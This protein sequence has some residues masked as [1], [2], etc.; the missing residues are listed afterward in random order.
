MRDS[1]L[2]V[3]S[4]LH[5]NRNPLVGRRLVASSNGLRLVL[6]FPYVFPVC[7]CQA[8]LNAS[9]CTIHGYRKQKDKFCSQSNY[10]FMMLEG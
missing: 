2:A 10:F 1:T 6:F 3:S 7:R 9:W 8:K 4:S 5:L